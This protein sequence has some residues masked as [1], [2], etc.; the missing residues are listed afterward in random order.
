[1]QCGRVKKV[2]GRREQ[3]SKEEEK[4]VKEEEERCLG[5]LEMGTGWAEWSEGGRVESEAAKWS[6]DGQG[7]STSR[8]RSPQ[9]AAGAGAASVM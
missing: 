8:G 1:M 7:M 4:E 6:G 3:R 2:R 5:V 9:A